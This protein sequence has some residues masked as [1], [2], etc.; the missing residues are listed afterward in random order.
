MAPLTL[1]TRIV[2]PGRRVQELAAE[3]LA[4]ERRSSAP[5]RCACS[6]C[7]R[8]PRGAAAPARRAPSAAMPPVA[9]R[10]P[11]RFALDGSSEASFAGDRDGDALAL[12]TLASSARG[13]CGCACATRCCAGEPPTPLARLAATADFGN[14][15][16]AA[17][18]FDRF[19]FINADLTIHLHRAA[20]GRVDRPRRA[21][22]AA[23]RRYRRRR[24]RAA[25]RARRRRARVSDARRAA[26]LSCAH[27]IERGSSL[28]CVASSTI[29]PDLRIASVELAVATSTA[30]STSTSACSGSPLSRATPTARC[31]DPTVETRRSRCRAIDRPTPLSPH[32]SGLFHVAWLHPSR[33]A[34]AD[35]VR[36]V[37]GERWPI[38][39]ASD[40]GV[41]EALYLAIPTG[42]ASRSTPTAR[43]SSG[44]ARRTATACGW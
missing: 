34:L 40:H 11:L 14:G 37:A 28:G 23:R 26:A 29:D 15:V 20:R 43:A 39:G 6:A 9:E 22:A 8:R 38:D 2:R 17:L 3:L 18:P 1:S 27:A 31:S 19:L 33:G 24:K 4:G 21:H 41:S 32:A 5:A 13:A 10:E 35:T 30:A 25:R 44:S 12:A 16:S 36:R 42:W 7:P